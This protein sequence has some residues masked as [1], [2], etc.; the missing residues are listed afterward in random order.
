QEQRGRLAGALRRIYGHTVH[1]NIT[2]DPLLVGGIRVEIGDEAIDGSV[3]S[4]LDEAR[5]RLVG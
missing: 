4:R 5:R 3:L 1:L 2:L